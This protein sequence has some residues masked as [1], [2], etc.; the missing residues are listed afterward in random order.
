MTLLLLFLGALGI[1]LLATVAFVAFL[2]FGDD[3]PEGGVLVLDVGADLPETLPRSARWFAPA[4]PDF[5]Q[6]TRALGRAASD[7]RIRGLLLRGEGVT[8][9]WGRL[10]ELRDA[11]AA[12]AASGKPVVASFEAPGIRDYLLATAADR[13][14]LHPRGRLMLFGTP[15][16]V[17]FYGEL[18]EKAGVGAQFEAIGPFK[19]A[20]DV[21]TR[22]GMT[23]AHREQLAVLA[24]DFLDLAADAVAGTRGLPPERARELLSGGPFL[25]AEGRELGLV[26]ALGYP[27]QAEEEFEDPY[28]LSL[29]DY[30]VGDGGWALP[31][32]AVIHVDGAILPGDSTTDP[33]AGRVAGA[34]TVREALEEVGG[35]DSVEAVVLRISSPGGADTAADTIWRAAER[36]RADKPVV[37]SLGDVAASGGY[38]VAAAARHVVA[39]PVSI[40]GSIGVYAGKLHLGGLF[41]KVG[42]G[43]ESVFPEGIPPNNWTSLAA[44]LRPAERERLREGVADTYAVFLERVA[45]AR[46]MTPEQVDAVAQGRVWSGRRALEMGLVDELGGL[47]AALRQARIEAGIP[48]D[49]EIG[50][51]HLPE[52]PGFAESLL[53]DLDAVGPL[54]RIPLLGALLRGGWFALLPFVPDPA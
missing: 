6:A 33:V 4:S 30:A 23:D 28:F 39:S 34:R 38:W 25:A 18:L 40:T 1:A 27:D 54:G 37:A 7:D 50:I 48:E 8:L 15:V 3:V 42:I 53:R 36:V 17:L 24:G 5:H 11:V 19:N 44:P 41:E 9:G 49:E 47:D 16:G 26:D 43:A 21:Y 46:G 32:I 13:I 2:A 22:A 45:A 52:P 29:Q 10:T 20:P 14:V 31:R 51:L 35:M 12:F